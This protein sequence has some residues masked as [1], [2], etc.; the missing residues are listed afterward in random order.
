MKTPTKK[1][2]VKNS[3]SKKKSPLLKYQFGGSDSYSG[4]D[5]GLDYEGFNADFSP[6]P[7]PSL[8]DPKRYESASVMPGSSSQ[9]MPTASSPSAG[10]I[11]GSVTGAM[12]GIGSSVM[13]GLQDTSVKDPSGY[14]NQSTIDRIERARKGQKEA[15]IASGIG[16]TISSIA[17]MTGPAAP[18][19]LAIGALTTAGSEIARA[20][21]KGTEGKTIGNYDE[22]VRQRNLQ[23]QRRNRMLQQQN[24]YSQPNYFDLGETGGL[25]KYMGGG[26]TK[27]TG[28]PHENGGVPMDLSG[29]GVLDS[30][31][32]GGEIIETMRGGGKS[33]QKYIWSDHLKK[34][35]KSFAK[36]FEEMKRK[37]KS[38]AAIEGLRVDQEIAANRDPNMLYA[39]Y[40]GMMKYQT[41]GTEKR[42][43]R[44]PFQQYLAEPSLQGSGRHASDTLIHNDPRRFDFDSPETWGQ[45]M[46]RSG[47]DAA[48]AKAFTETYTDLSSLLP[49]GEQYQE[50]R[51]YLNYLENARKTPQYNYDRTGAGTDAYARV[52]STPIYQNGGN[53]DPLLR[54]PNYAAQY[55]TIPY[56]G[57]RGTQLYNDPFADKKKYPVPQGM[58]FTQRDSLLGKR[59]RGIKLTPSEKKSLGPE[60]DPNFKMFGRVPSVVDPSKMK[61]GGKMNYMKE[62]GKLPKDV[63]KS[64]LES[65]MSEGEAQN[66][67]DS[68][69]GGGLWDNIHAKRKRIAAGSEEKMRKPGSEGAPT[70]K[71]LRESK[72]DG[73]YLEYKK[74]GLMKYQTAGTYTVQAGDSLSAI[75]QAQGV[76]DY[77]EIYNLNKAI[78]GSD[79]GMIKPG[80]V[81]TMPGA[82]PA[83][84]PASPAAPVSTRSYPLAGYAGVHPLAG[85]PG[86]GGT[87]YVSAPVTPYT[88]PSAS[89]TASTPPPK[90]PKSIRKELPYG[91][92]AAGA[93]GQIATVASIDAKKGV[94]PINVPYINQPEEE[95]FTRV[96]DTGKA[97]REAERRA[98]IREIN[99]ATGPQKFALA[100]QARATL[101]R[102]EEKA[103]SNIDAMNTQ[104]EQAEITLN[105]SRK[106]S[107]DFKN[108]EI[109]LRNAMSTRDEALRVLESV[110]NKK[111]A[112]GDIFRGATKD[113]LQYYSAEELARAT[114]GERGVMGRFYDN[115]YD[116]FSKQYK[117]QNPGASP[118]ETYAAFQTSLT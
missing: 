35:G 12:S 88:R 77:N 65:H 9:A 109:A 117:K 100:D 75:A 4:F 2:S 78:I 30:E 82:A 8:S 72:R 55:D 68:Y 87:G 15:G 33:G 25:K 73:G 94:A 6:Y 59:D 13:A 40:G 63:L 90:D 48:L 98:T 38:Q 67:I 107:I 115:P 54:V 61:N 64:R 79:P 21:Y 83:A 106:D 1:S 47:D 20:S 95:Y 104:I 76:A 80:Q 114:E 19:L 31:L 34:G 28:P 86:S 96:R 66:Y 91:I 101:L 60:A 18:F 10:A 5:Q 99:K 103:K 84:S 57:G 50:D 27:V 116:K 46:S 45:P 44:T 93:L 105:T 3:K 22:R 56:S 36:N 85:Y 69:K 42:A 53:E 113:I 74:G 29:D 108:S 118:Q 17:P 52:K 37:G 26:F 102:E 39:K 32:E 49:G 7:S 62:G 23:K 70:A 58:Q 51:G 14:F 97:G 41:A 16:T 92:A 110:N 111:K 43:K 11:A 24:M 81:L 71:A 89:S 112:Y